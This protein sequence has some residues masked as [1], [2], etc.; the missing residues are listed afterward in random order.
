MQLQN[1]PPARK[2]HAPGAQSGPHVF[3]PSPPRPSTNQRC[4][5]LGQSFPVGY[6]ART[7]AGPGRRRARGPAPAARGPPPPS[8]PPARC[9]HPV[10]LTRDDLAGWILHRLQQDPERGLD[11]ALIDADSLPK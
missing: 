10:L 11:K 8:S 5:D 4:L 3:T 6:P 9:K 2:K 7:L 1:W